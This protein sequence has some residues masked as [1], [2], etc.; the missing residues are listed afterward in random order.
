MRMKVQDSDVIQDLKDTIKNL[1]SQLHEKDQ[2]YKSLSDQ[3]EKYK[4]ETMS[5]MGNRSSKAELSH[6]ESI[7]S[8]ED[9]ER[10]SMVKE[11]CLTEIDQNRQLI[12]K[13]SQKYIK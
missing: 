11:N 12:K 5:N 3:Y 2:A 7:V 4:T 10:K 1:V 9:R 13:S 6:H 8:I